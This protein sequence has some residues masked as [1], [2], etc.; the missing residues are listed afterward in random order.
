MSETQPS[1]RIGRSIGAVVAGIVV[2]ITF[3]LGTDMA[4]RAAGIFP[5]P[6]QPAMSNA[7]FLLA[8][9]Y[10]IIYG[11]LGSYVIARLA[12]GRPMRHALIGGLVGLVASGVGAVATWN[13]V[14]L[15]GAALVST[16]AC[17]N[18]DTLRLAGRQIGRETVARERL[19]TSRTAIQTTRSG[20][21]RRPNLCGAGFDFCFATDC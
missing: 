13:H 20:T 2:G 17:C 14:A 7:L 11:I 3:S 5:P 1:R 4:L 15:A 10:R 12:P 6:E 18:R 9:G 16:R 19:R 21:L 8:T